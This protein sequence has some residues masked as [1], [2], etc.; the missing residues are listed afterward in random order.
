MTSSPPVPHSHRTA[1]ETL[2]HAITDGTFAVGSELRLAP[3][4]ARSGL[5]EPL[6]AAAVAV[7]AAKGLVTAA[8]R[9]RPQR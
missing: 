8:R 5:A 9:V 7:L 2:A 3:L 4:A 6:L 1:V